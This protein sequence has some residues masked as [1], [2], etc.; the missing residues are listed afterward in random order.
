MLFK[1]YLCCRYFSH[2]NQKK[3]SAREE[4]KPIHTRAVRAHEYLHVHNWKY[5]FDQREERYLNRIKRYFDE[6]L[7]MRVEKGMNKKRIG[8]NS[9]IT[10]HKRLQIKM[11]FIQT[12]LRAFLENPCRIATCG[13]ILIKV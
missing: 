12:S 8:I 13:R 3:L 6:H 2:N 11:I 9:L 10:R 7:L 5:T 1:I 4:R